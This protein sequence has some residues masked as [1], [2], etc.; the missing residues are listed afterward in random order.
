[1]LV[2]DGRCFEN[3]AGIAF[4]QTNARDQII[5][6]TDEGGDRINGK[7]LFDG[8]GKFIANGIVSVIDKY[9]FGLFGEA[10]EPNVNS[11]QDVTTVAAEG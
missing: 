4:F 3:A 2:W 11:A 7:L 9:G 1:M 6:G 10:A 8:T 5:F